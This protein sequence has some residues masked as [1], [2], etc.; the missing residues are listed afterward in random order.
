[1][2]DSLG[3]SALSSP[4]DDDDTP[5]TAVAPS[6]AAIVGHSEDAASDHAKK[7]AKTTRTFEVEALKGK[8]IPR[9]PVASRVLPSASF[10]KPPIDAAELEPETLDKAEDLKSMGKS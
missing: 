9:M 5:T 8:K 6:Q 3:A 10:E 7:P 2:M 4:I 1:M